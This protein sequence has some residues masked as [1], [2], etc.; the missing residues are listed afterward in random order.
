LWSPNGETV[1]F[2][3][4]AALFRKDT[5][6]GGDPERIGQVDNLL[7]TDWSPDG[8]FVLCRR[9]N[10]ETGE[11]LWVLPVTPEGRLAQGQ[12][13]FAYLTTPFNESQGRFSREAGG[14]HWVAYESNETGRSEIYIA[15]FPHPT[16][17]L[18]ITTKGGTYPEW[19]LQ[20]RELFYVSSDNKLMAVPIKQASNTWQPLQPRELLPL[21]PSVESSPYANVS[22]GRR[23]AVRTST[24]EQAFELI[25]N[26]PRLHRP[27]AK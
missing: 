17:R 10:P 7:P 2:G 4:G 9:R 25:L 15:T 22:D 14:P 1:L 5:A 6:G 18:Q 12:R 27:A 19:G 11:D 3:G 16:R 26:W 23:F 8:K 21:S 24:R 13:P 20:G